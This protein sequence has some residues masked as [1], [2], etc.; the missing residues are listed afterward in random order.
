MKT[1][2][3]SAFTL[4]ELLAVIAI[5]GILSG[6]L[7][8]AIGHIMENARRTTAANNLHQISIAANAYMRSG[9]TAKTIRANSV[10]DWAL[11]L[12]QNT[13]LNDATLYILNEDPLVIS[14]NKE[15]PGQIAFTDSNGKMTINSNFATMPISFAV[16]SNIAPNAPVSTTPIAWTR[17]LQPSG[18]WA[19]EDAT[20]PGV[21]G[22]RGGHIVYLDGH[23]EYYE[24]LLGEDGSGRLVNYYTKQPT[25]NI[26]EALNTGAAILDVDSSFGA[27]INDPEP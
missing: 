21:Y 19:A 4:I 14:Q 2:S 7:Y 13:G 20:C 11:L 26:E 25:V 16:V 3:R 24:N 23:V 6:M 5:I 8:P 18:Y 10:H 9:P 1:Y 22:I 17:G 27:P 12:S 15:T